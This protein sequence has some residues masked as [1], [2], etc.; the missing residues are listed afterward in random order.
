MSVVL[1]E[2]DDFNIY[3]DG[4]ALGFSDP[5]YTS[6]LSNYALGYGGNTWDNDT[7]S[8]YT[9]TYLAVY[10]EQNYGGDYAV[11]PPGSHDLASLNA[12]GIE[13]DDIA[14]FYAFA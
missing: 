1:Y 2:N 8:L 9:T 5:A 7:S 10:E 13:N 6:D 12:Y 11:L 3:D 4:Y 14:S